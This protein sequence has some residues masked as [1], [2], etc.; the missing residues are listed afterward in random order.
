[1]FVNGFKSYTF[2]DNSHI[3]RD[4]EVKNIAVHFELEETEDLKNELGQQIMLC[5][6][7]DEIEDV[8]YYLDIYFND[9]DVFTGER[10]TWFRIQGIVNYEYSYDL[11]PSVTLNSEASENLTKD[12]F[13]KAI[14]FLAN[15]KE[16][17]MKC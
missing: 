17:M 1:M 9:K 13:Y 5:K 4:D 15:N 11:F 12:L 3:A 8:N 6:E 16:G 14:D 7:F 10:A 2:S